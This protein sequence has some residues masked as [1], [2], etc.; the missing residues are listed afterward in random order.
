VEGRKNRL[1]WHFNGPDT[2]QD[3]VIESNPTRQKVKDPLHPE[4]VLVVS[5]ST[6]AAL[7]AA[8]KEG[9]T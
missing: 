6:V 2:I 5:D 4:S 7:L 9:R 1:R 3:T 8:V